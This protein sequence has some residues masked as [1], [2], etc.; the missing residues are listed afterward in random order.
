[1]AHPPDA[2]YT[3][4]PVDPP[5]GR[6]GAGHARSP[7][8]LN[9][10]KLIEQPGSW[11]AIATYTNRTTARSVADQLRAARDGRPREKGRTIPPSDMSRWTFV[12][13]QLDDGRWGVVAVYQT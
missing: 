1:M 2:D 10:L 11:A 3:L 9:M 5:A 4:R 12:H 6:D 7:I 13:Q 8:Y